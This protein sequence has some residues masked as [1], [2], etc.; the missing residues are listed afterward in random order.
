MTEKPKRDQREYEIYNKYST[1]VLV[2]KMMVAVERLGDP[3]TNRPCVSGV[4]IYPPKTMAVVVA[5]CEHWNVGYRRT[6]ATLRSH[7]DLLKRLGLARVPCRSTIGNA[8]RRIPR[9]YLHDLN[10]TITED[11]RPGSVAG[12]STGL[13]GSRK[14]VWL[15]VRTGD[16]KAKKGWMKLH[17]PRPQIVLIYRY[18]P[19]A[20]SGCPRKAASRPRDTPTKSAPS[21]RA[22]PA[23]MTVPR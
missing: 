13:S 11:I 17:T 1:G 16:R 20:P 12:D 4:R 7:G 22:A 21:K 9:Q 6:A 10:H 3:Y 5:L 19:L 23:L 8:Y 18:L 15:D 14:V 2:T